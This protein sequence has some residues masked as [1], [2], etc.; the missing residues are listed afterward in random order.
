MPH[1]WSRRQVVQGAGAVGLGL[2][3]GCGRWPGQ[4]EPSRKVPR[5]GFL[6][7]ALTASSPETEALRQGLREH[8]YIEGQN[9]A[10]EWR[11]AEGRLD[12]LPDLAVELVSLPVDI[13]MTAGSPATKAVMQATSTI[14]IVIAVSSD[15]VADE[16]VASLARPGA[17]V[18]GLTW[19]SAQ[20]SGKRLELLKEVVPGLSRVAVLA[21]ADSPEA[22]VEFAG[23]QPLAEILGMYLQPVMVSGSNP[24]FESAL[25]AA[26][27]GHAEALIVLAMGQ[28]LANRTAIPEFAAKAR[29][30]AMYSSGD[31]VAAGGLMAYGPNRQQSYRRAAYYVD[32]ILK[33]AKPADLPVEQPREFDF[34]INLRTAEALGLTIP[35]H[36]LLQATEV[37]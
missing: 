22:A 1:R 15:A 20:L 19:M 25:A 33:G 23:T 14:P 21:P 13:I 17:N 26:A 5:I 11:S 3:A 30:P 10:L 24:D 37:S 7:G 31:W 29:L 18:T 28:I 8:G 9:I 32:R 34:V 2:L 12:R 35:Q 36:V 27:T 16:L 4:A 6:W